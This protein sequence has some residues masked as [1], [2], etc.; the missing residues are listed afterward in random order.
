M[1]VQENSPFYLHRL[2]SGI[3]AIITQSQAPVSYL[4][5]MINAGS[6]D[7][8]P[9]NY[10]LAHFIEHTI[11]KGTTTRNSRQI[12]D[13]IENIGGEINAYTTKEE[14]TLY[15]CV[16]N[17]YVER[18]IELM[19]DMLFHPTFP[20]DKI[21]SERQVIIEEIES[22][23]DSPAEQ[24]YDDFEELVY[25][26]HPLGHNILGTATHVKRFA[27]SDAKRFMAEHYHSDGIVFFCHTTHSAE[28]V[29]DWVQKHL[30]T[31][32]YTSPR[33]PREKPDAYMVKRKPFVL[34]HHQ[35]HCVAGNVVMDM[36]GNWKKIPVN[37]LNHI[38][39][40]PCMN[41][42]LNLLLREKYGLVYNIESSVQHFCDTGLW[43]LYF[44]CDRNDIE[45][46]QE[47]I[48][49]DLKELCS[50][51]LSNM[52]LRKY[53]MQIRGQLAIAAQNPENVIL[54]YAKN[55]LHRNSL[56]TWEQLALK[57]EKINADTL[58]V[59]AQEY[60]APDKLSWIAI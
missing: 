11:F 48:E 30:Y 57:Y 37:M 33:T 7:E 49:K 23:K 45:R 52:Q 43:S 59:V 55:Y 9:S 3:R 12:I 51:L 38:I 17:K 34:K 15:C 24:I 4:G 21:D 47:L 1:E 46:C 41:S 53:K 20:E 60:F 8:K 35:A 42:R 27:A 36:F 19:T 31:V 6:R 39:A 25:G 13:R 22:Y 58:Q 14:T 32:P 29:C 18:A 28:R 44:G 54:T 56:Q 26:R 2:D 16:P 10:G 5:F 50:T 40:G